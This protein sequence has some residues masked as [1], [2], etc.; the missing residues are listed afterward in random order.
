MKK[1]EICQMESVV[2]GDWLNNHTLK[3][4]LICVGWG[5]LAS[6]YGPAGTVAAMIFCYA[7]T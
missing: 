5:I 2:G 7:S 1:L 6:S 3:E 4:H